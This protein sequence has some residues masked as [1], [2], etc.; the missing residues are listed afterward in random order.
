MVPTNVPGGWFSGTA[1][2][3]DGEWQIVSI[4]DEPEAWLD[5]PMLYLASHRPLAWA[6]ADED[7]TQRLH[8]PSTP[9]GSCASRRSGPSS[10]TNRSTI[11]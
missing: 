9:S 10:W 2:V 6:G 8:A 5:A 1:A 11:R 4:E 7:D 3:E